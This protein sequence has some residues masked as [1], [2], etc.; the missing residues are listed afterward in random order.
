MKMMLKN[1][2]IMNLTKYGALFKAKAIG[3]LLILL[4]KGRYKHAAALLRAYGWNTRN[5]VKTLRMRRK[6]QSSIRRVSD[7]RILGR[8]MTVSDYN[9]MKKR[10]KLPDA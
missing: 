3:Y 1:Y 6:V 2:S 8:M 10:Y 5:I 7:E 9:S 4:F